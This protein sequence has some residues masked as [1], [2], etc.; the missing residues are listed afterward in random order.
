MWRRCEA[1]L[2]CSRGVWFLSPAEREQGIL[3]KTQQE[4][5]SSALRDR[6]LRVK[7]GQTEIEQRDREIETERAPERDTDNDNS[8]FPSAYPRGNAAPFSIE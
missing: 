7:K 3:G 5:Q 8:G 6:R 4:R 1:Q 2:E